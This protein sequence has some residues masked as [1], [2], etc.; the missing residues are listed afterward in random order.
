MPEGRALLAMLQHGDSFFPSGSVSFSWGVET[1]GGDGKI[2]KAA[3]LE[4]YVTHQLNGRWASTDR[5]VLAA[6]HGAAGDL[7]KILI[8]DEMMEANSLAHEQ[9]VG[10]KRMGAALL[11]VHVRLDT[12]GA[13]DYQAR[14]RGDTAPGHVA[15]VQGLLWHAIGV[16][17]DT[18][19]RMAAHGLSVGLLGAALRLGIIGHVD[20]QAILGCL[21][22]TIEDILGTPP[23]PLDG[24]HAYAP[25]ADIAMMRHETQESRLFYN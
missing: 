15:A 25:A 14:V 7:E 18:A 3:D 9:R 22:A 17:A 1:L 2:L 6:A 4:R 13:R 11:N 21:H 19:C 20:S 10:S 23:P 8:A 12:A 24:L 16:D 5:P